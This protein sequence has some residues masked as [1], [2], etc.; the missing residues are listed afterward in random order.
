MSLLMRIGAIWGNQGTTTPLTGSMSG[1]LRV[2][3]AHAKYFQP[4]IEGRL[5]RLDSGSITLAA[6]NITGTAMG[7]VKF[8]NGFFNPLGSGKHAVILA[9]HVATVSGL[10]GGPYFW[11]FFQA[12]AL[13]NSAAS[14]TIRNSLLGQG[15]ANGGSL[16]SPQ[17]NATVTCIGALTTAMTRLSVMGGPAAIT[18]GAGLYDAVEEVD[19]RIIIPPGMNIAILCAAVGTAHVVQSSLIWEEV[20]VLS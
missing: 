17:V 20:P 3:Q 15:G 16:M 9:A 14:G 19:G 13:I 12:G 1:A 10:P 8:I 5:L 6:A 2:T 7:T 11:E 18:A 4:A